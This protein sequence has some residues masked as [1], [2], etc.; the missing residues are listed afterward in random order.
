MIEILLG[1]RITMSG[2]AVIPWEGAVVIMNHRTRLDWN[3][4]WAAYY[5]AAHPHSHSLKFILKAPI[6]HIPGP[7]T[8]VINYLH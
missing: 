7:G 5:H 8:Y 4:L 1:V 6:M 3:F 2:E